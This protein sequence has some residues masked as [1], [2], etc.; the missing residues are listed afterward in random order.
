MKV[1]PSHFYAEHRE[2]LTGLVDSAAPACPGR[3]LVLGAGSCTDLNLAELVGRFAEVHLVDIDADAMERGVTDQLSPGQRDGVILHCLDLTGIAMEL[4]ELRGNTRQEA[5]RLINQAESRLLPIPVGHFSVVVSAGVL[6]Q[7]NMHLVSCIDASSSN[8]IP[9]LQAIRR[10]HVN[11]ML[12]AL[13]KGGQGII[14]VDVV[15]SVT[16]PALLEDQLVGGMLGSELATAIQSSNFF[17]GMNPLAIRVAVEQD[18]RCDH[19]VLLDPWR[20]TIGQ[21]TY[22]TTAVAFRRR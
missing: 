10:A 21:L 17:H 12:T 20:W 22:G 9:F 2:R 13:Q 14:V 19:T 11:Q 5:Q 7:L 4:D 8:F 1:D 15:S 18:D 3:L 6:S 16:L